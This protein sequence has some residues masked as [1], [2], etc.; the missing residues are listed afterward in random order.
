[1]L[2]FWNRMSHITAHHHHLQMD[3]TDFLLSGSSNIPTTPT[4]TP[5]PTLPLGSPMTTPNQLS[6]N[7][8]YL[9]EI[10]IIMNL[11]ENHIQSKFCAGVRACVC[12]VL[13]HCTELC[14]AHKVSR[15]A[16]ALID[17]NLWAWA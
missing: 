12:Q 8:I 4:P 7:A 14:V 11:R 16:L 17:L 6:V 1:M 2:F 3:L 13:V 15:N 10:E 9:I 5:T